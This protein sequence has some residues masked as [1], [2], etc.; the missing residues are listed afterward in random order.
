M[1]AT[2]QSWQAAQNSL[3]RDLTREMENS[4]Q[5]YQTALTEINQKFQGEENQKNREDAHNRLVMTHDWQAREAA[6]GRIYD[7]EKTLA[8]QEFAKEQGIS[9]QAFRIRLAEF[10][11]SLP[12]DTQRLYEKYFEPDEIGDII[13]KSITGKTTAATPSAAEWIGK[14]LDDEDLMMTLREDVAQELSSRTGTKVDPDTVTVDQL[15]QALS[16]LYDQVTGTS[17]SS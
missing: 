1:Q 11:A 15:R 14:R 7:L 13:V 16:G 2:N 17:P 10:T 3:N 9:D 4:R 8:A 6:K 12:S 5:Q